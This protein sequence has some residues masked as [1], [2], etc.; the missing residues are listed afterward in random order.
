[1]SCDC[2]DNELREFPSSLGCVVTSGYGAS[3]EGDILCF[4]GKSVKENEIISIEVV[5]ENIEDVALFAYWYYIELESGALSFLLTIPIFGIVK[6]W[7]VKMTKGINES[8]LNDGSART[9]K[10][11]LKLITDIT[12]TIDDEVGDLLCENI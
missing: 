8:I 11:D 3:H 6:A 1:M 10:I 12:S 7:E 4:A 9:I 2:V 5:T